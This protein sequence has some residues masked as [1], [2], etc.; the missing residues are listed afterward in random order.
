MGPYFYYGESIL[1]KSDDCNIAQKCASMGP[2]VQMCI[3][4]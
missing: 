4:V 3:G 2:Y 1:R